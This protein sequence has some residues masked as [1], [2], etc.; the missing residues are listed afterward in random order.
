MSKYK[1]FSP[2]EGQCKCGCGLNIKDEVYQFLDKI[3]EEIGLPITITSGA[4]C[5]THNTRVGGSPTSD[6]MNCWCAD[7]TCKSVISLRD[8]VKEKHLKELDQLIYY[9]KN[10]FLHISVSPKKRNQYFEK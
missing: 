10:N 9:P 3:R 2:T 5:K 8:L 6:H 4:R 7:I 1:Y